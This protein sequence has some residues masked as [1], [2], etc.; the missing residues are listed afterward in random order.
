MDLLQKRKYV[1]DPASKL[2]LQA[3]EL[4]SPKIQPNTSRMRLR[5]SRMTT[6]LCK[7][8]STHLHIHKITQWLLCI[9]T[10][11]GY[12]GLLFFNRA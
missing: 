2:G 4:T 9:M 1:A 5:G 8:A 10:L 3:N 12:A 11:M 6:T 7:P